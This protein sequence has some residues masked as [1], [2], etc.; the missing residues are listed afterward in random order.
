MSHKLIIDDITNNYKNCM[1]T[2]ACIWLVLVGQ[3]LHFFFFLTSAAISGR[4]CFLEQ[5]RHESHHSNICQTFKS[6]IWQRLESN[7]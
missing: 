1:L 5:N 6:N 4:C 3:N 7:I 2:I